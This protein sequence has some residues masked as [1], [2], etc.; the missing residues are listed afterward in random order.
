[1]NRAEFMAALEAQLRDITTEE[2]DEALKFYNE[3]LDEAG[4]ENEA[5]VLGRA[6]QPQRWP[7]SFAQTAASAYP[8]C[9]M[10]R[11]KA[12][13]GKAG[14]G[15]RSG[16][17]T[18][19]PGLAGVPG[20]GAGNRTL[21]GRR[22]ARGRGS[23]GRF[24]ECAGGG[25]RAARPCLCIQLS[26]RRRAP[27]KRR[28]LRLQPHALGHPAHSHLSHLDRP[29]RRP[30]RRRS[31]HRRRAVRHCVRGLCHNDRGR[32]GFRRRRWAAVHI[33]SQ[34]WHPDDGS[35][36]AVH[37]HPAR[38]WSAGTVW[39]VAKA[40][41]RSSVPSVPVSRTLFGKVR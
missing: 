20:P 9:V 13:L 1:M 31:G 36:P 3:Y 7:A 25:R 5:A 39:V 41:Q 15:A 37:L 14:T 28:T 26:P 6:G 40:G 27:R 10:Q 23:S 4:P 35:Q 30:V 8:P 22:P 29:H 34:W 38:C 32:G 18:G 21:L 19:R 2:R 16:A 17:Y 11:K 33:R 24:S 12:P